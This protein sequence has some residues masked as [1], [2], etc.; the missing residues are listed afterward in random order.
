MSYREIF[1]FDSGVGKM[2]NFKL[3]VF[4]MGVALNLCLPTTYAFNSAAHIYIAE[5]VLGDQIID[6]YYGSISPDIASYA[7]PEKW[8]TAFEDSWHGRCSG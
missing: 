1:L 8:P 5:H 7:N 2:K 6:L 3:V 4:L